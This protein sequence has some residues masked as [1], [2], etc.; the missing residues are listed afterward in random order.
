[1]FR[2]TEIAQKPDYENEIIAIIRSNASPKS[3]R[4]K[5]EDYH[6]NDIAEI[7]SKLTLQEQK[8][9]YR[10]LTVSMLSCIF[11]YTN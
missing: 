2:K 1:M 5:L 8:K 7:L 9:L 11:E 4:E 3:M 6:E 10:I